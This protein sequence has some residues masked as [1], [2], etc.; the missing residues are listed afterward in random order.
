MNR[1]EIQVFDHILERTDFKDCAGKINISIFESE[2]RSWVPYFVYLPPN[3]NK[4]ETYPLV[5]FLHGQGGDEGTFNKYV[6]A[7]QLNK[8]ILSGD[9]EPVVIAGIRGDNN[10]DNVQW[11]TEEN[12]SLLIQEKGGEFLQFCQNSFNAGNQ[13]TRISIEGHSR[14]AAGAIHYY[15]KYPNLFS[16]IL[17][18]GYVSDYTLDNNFLQGRNNLAMIKR[19]ATPLRLEIGTE[20]SFVRMKNRRASFEIHQFLRENSIDHSFEILHGVEHG[21][22]TYWNYYSEE[23]MLNGLAHLKFHERSRNRNCR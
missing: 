4:E 14:G 3:W 1:K 17:A 13:G 18:M 11:F 7:E 12:E 8:W 2:V 23:D 19:E 15:L 6:Q 10:R 20:D 21:F 22:D 9:I 5:L 16:S